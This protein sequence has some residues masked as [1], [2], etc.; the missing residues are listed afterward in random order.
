M[1]GS[2]SATSSVCARPAQ[3]GGLGR[4]TVHRQGA[5]PR[6]ER[7]SASGSPPPASRAGPR[8]RRGPRPTPCRKRSWRPGPAAGSTRAVRTRGPGPRAAAARTP[9]RPRGGGSRDQQ[10]VPATRLPSRISTARQMGPRSR[11]KLACTS[12]GRAA[13]RSRCSSGV[14]LR[15]V[16]HLEGRVVRSG[17]R[18]PLAAIPVPCER[19]AVAARRGVVRAR[20]TRLLRCAGSTGRRRL[21]SMA[22]L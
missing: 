12:V 5:G 19:S 10:P 22:W 6:G 16:E 17:V 13:M 20:S 11:S 8:V 21:S 15:E 7:R 3:V 2:S 4:R 9:R 14:C 1:R 18:E